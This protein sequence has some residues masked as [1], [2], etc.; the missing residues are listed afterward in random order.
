[1]QAHMQGRPSVGG[2]FEPLRHQVDYVARAELADHI[3]ALHRTLHGPAPLEICTGCAMLLAVE[4][5][6][7]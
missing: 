2:V 1:M 4:E 5:G 3:D 6:A 7:C